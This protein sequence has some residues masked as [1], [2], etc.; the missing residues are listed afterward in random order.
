MDAPQT[1]R[2]VPVWLT[3][4]PILMGAASLAA[5]LG[6]F[7]GM[8]HWP[9]ALSAMRVPTALGVIALAVAVNL[10]TAGWNRL[11]GTVALSPLA[12][13]AAVLAA[14]MGVASL[15]IDAPPADPDQ[16]A[17]LAGVDLASAVGS[18]LLILLGASTVLSASRPRLAQDL[19][20][21]IATLTIALAWLVFTC[22]IYGTNGLI[23]LEH[24]S[25]MRAATPLSAALIG[26]ALIVTRG[27]E[28]LYG[29]LFREGSGAAL[30]RHTLP[31]ALLGPF[32]VG[33]VAQLGFE[34]RSLGEGAGLAVTTL[35]VTAAMISLFLLFARRLE[36]AERR[37]R[38]AARRLALANAALE[39]RVGRRTE[40]LAVARDT[41][42]RA[43]QA[44]TDFLAA[45][46]HEIRTPLTGVLGIA[47]LLAA[48]PL[49]ARQNRYVRAIRS[50]G[51]QLLSI[52]NDI[53]DFSKL[54]TGKID[55]ERIPF[56][57]DG[58]L[59]EVISVMS[60]RAHETRVTLR[61]D[62]GEGVPPAVVGDPTRLKQILFNLV[63]NALKF[64]ER[65]SVIVRVTAE[66]RTEE[67]SYV[68]FAVVD[69]GIGMSEAQQATLFQE[70][71]QG[72]V[73]MTRRY[74]G[75][76]LGLAICRRLVEV[77]D[78]DIGVESRLG[79]GSRFWVDLPLRAAELPPQSSAQTLVPI[80]LDPLRILLAEDVELNR[81]L[82]CEALGRQ[83]H[84]VVAVN[85]GQQA[86]E[87]A[88]KGGFDIVLMDVQMPVLDGI[89]ATR[90]IRAL[91][92]PV[93]TVPI[94]AL[95]ASVLESSRP[96]LLKAGMNDWAMKPIVWTQLFE[97]LARYGGK[98]SPG[99]RE[100]PDTPEPQ[101]VPQ[102]SLDLATI[103]GLRQLVPEAK[104]GQMLAAAL[105]SA[106]SV[107]DRLT[108]GHLVGNE[109]ARLAHQLRGTLSTYG[110]VE[111]GR[112][113]GEIEDQAVSGAEIETSTR[114]LSQA[115]SDARR[116]LA[117]LFATERVPDGARWDA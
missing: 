5:R 10:L 63:G 9:G 116:D 24:A 60:P 58:L 84:M 83:G 100:R 20:E 69:T 53:L 18:L 66:P 93:G 101:S 46:S 71:R 111:I 61:I 13:G 47:D 4:P 57:L 34:G 64:T 67:R 59:E 75:S 92:P 70:F 49:T 30:A 43:N 54:R 11:A 15:G 12:I 36:L 39:R 81:D 88:R 19:A 91:P 2:W 38:L 21:V 31:A 99:A 104:L 52:V 35:G 85:D 23:D 22:M 95:T 17:T 14:G 82:I 115:V 51:Q 108:A 32:A 98:A 117:M 86:V 45:M 106:A 87:A 37:T 1:A 25:S 28:G 96:A 113:A 16:A 68:R 90:R 44:K 65:G 56:M 77:M 112:L 105:E 41:A 26:V 80:A 73:S 114:R 94:L 50:S 3:L 72:D 103:E 7:A 6:L 78:G 79:K 48:E 109:T 27:D 110:F 42:E 97:L 33:L 55:L 29:F 8:P 74:G 76:G 40:E 102:G 107:A 89:E 62:K